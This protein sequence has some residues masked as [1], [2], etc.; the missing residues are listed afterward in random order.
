[1]INRAGF[2][3]EFSCY[4]LLMEWTLN[5]LKKDVKVALCANGEKRM[6]WKIVLGKESCCRRVLVEEN[7]HY[8]RM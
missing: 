5:D 7:Q 1:M 6:K 3:I 4:V 8:V 2:L